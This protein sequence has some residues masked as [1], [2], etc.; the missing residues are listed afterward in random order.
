MSRQNH[1]RISVI[2]RLE[3]LEQLDGRPITQVHH[4][5]FQIIKFANFCFDFFVLVLQGFA[6]TVWVITDGP[7]CLL[8]SITILIFVTRLISILLL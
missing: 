6:G 4:L 3:H 5:I 2:S 8:Y 7:L 1:Y